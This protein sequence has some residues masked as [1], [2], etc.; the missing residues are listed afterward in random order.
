MLVMMEMSNC[1]TSQRK[2]GQD[3]LRNKSLVGL[4]TFSL[5]VPSATAMTYFGKKFAKIVC[6]VTEFVYHSDC[7][8]IFHCQSLVRDLFSVKMS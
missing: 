6:F 8:I 2:R 7:T 5:R 3:A 1:N 4:E